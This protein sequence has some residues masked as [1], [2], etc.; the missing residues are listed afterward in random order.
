MSGTTR[1]VVVPGVPALLPRFAGVIDPVADMRAACLTAVAWLLH[2]SPDRVVLLGA[3][4]PYSVNVGR[5]LL[6]VSRF[7]GEIEVS[8]LPG[9]A[10]DLGGAAV[11]AV[12]DGSACRSEKAPGYLDERA[13]DFDAAVGAALATGDHKALA[14]LDED[15]GKDLWAAGAPVLRALGCAVHIVDSAC[16]SYTGDPFGVQYW[17]ARW[18]TSTRGQS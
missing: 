11:L 15:L 14:T 13:F 10:P 17:V 2:D 16:V 5:H 18:T 9:P 3:R 1:I 4:Q 8:L 7:S 12:A 6:G